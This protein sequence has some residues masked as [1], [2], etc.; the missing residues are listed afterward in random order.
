MSKPNIPITVP[1]VGE[2]EAEAAAAVVRSGWLAQGKQVARFEQAVTDFL[3]ARHAV[4]VSSCTAALHL[5]LVGLEIGPGDEVVVPSLSYVATANAVLYAGAR[6]LFAD[7]D[8][9]TYNIDPASVA[10]LITP[11]TRAIV[12][13]HQVGLAADLGPLREL[14]ARRDLALV[15]DAAC[16]LGSTYQGQLVGADS[17]VCCLSFHPRKIITCGEGGMLVTRDGELAQRLRVLRSQGMSV[18]A[19]VRHGAQRLVFEEYRQLGYNYRLTDI[20]AA[21]G[22]EQMKRLP[23]LLQQRRALALRYCE[24]LEPVEGVTPPLDS[25]P[26]S[27]AFQS[28]MVLLDPHID[29]GALMQ[30]LLNDG[31]SAR[32]AVQA[33]H[34]EPLYREQYPEL[35]LQN[36][37]QVFARGLMLPLYPGMEP[38][39]QDRV[40]EAVRRAVLA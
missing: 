38:G 28:F 5:A 31:I 3:G 15:E 1:V 16:A 36:T 17:Q 19:D 8:L 18:P 9:R 12:P 13:V 37:E 33:I 14:A 26:G 11:R 29:R 32:R 21:I 34:L 2:E 20:Q 39:D 23:S 6:P 4:A 27:H 24:L 40:V 7:I 10:R 22:V 25:E 30:Q 35:S